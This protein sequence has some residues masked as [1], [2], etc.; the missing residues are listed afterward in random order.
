MATP[1]RRRTSSRG[2]LIFGVVAAIALL[3]FS[4]TAFYTDVLWFREI[5][6]TSVLWTTISA[7][8]VTGAVVG[9]FVGLVVYVNLVIAGR[10]AS[11]YNLFRVEDTERPDPMDRYRMLLNPYVKW[12]RLAAGIALGLLAGFGAS[13][14]WQTF[15]LYLNR[16]SFGQTDPQFG[17]DIGFYFFELPFFDLVLDWAW[18]AIVAAL[19]VSLVAHYFHGSIQPEAGLS[20][21]SS[22]VMAHVSVL[23]GLLALVKAVQY[24]LGTFELNF[25]LRGTVTGASYTDINAQLPA[26]RLLAIISIISAVLFIANIRF[27]RL[28]LPLAAVGIWV[29]TAVLA[30]AAWPA[31]VQRFSVEPQEASRER[32][33]IE[34]NIEATREGYGLDVES[35]PIA[36]TDDLDTEAIEAN[37]TL[38]S[39]VRVWDPDVLQRVYNQLQAITPFYSF[40]DV[41]IDRYEVDGEIRQ[42]LLSG[43]EL[44]VEDLTEGRSWQNE[45]LIYTHGYGVVASLANES[46]VSGQPSFLVSELPGSV[47]RDAPDFELDEPGI[48][49]GE[50]Y[51]DSEYSIVNTE[52]AE[53]DY[54]GEG[55]EATVRSNYEGEG[56]IEMGGFLRKLAFAVRERDFNMVLSD[57]IRPDS[58]IMLYKDV[59]DRVRR[60]APFLALDDDPYI[61]A[62]DGG[63]KWILDGYTTSNFYPYSQRTD[64]GEIVQSTENGSLQVEANYVRNSVKVVVDAYDGTMDFHIVD[65]DDPLMEAWRKTFPDL[66]DAEA[67]SEE[68]EEHF[69]YPED[70]LL[71]QSEL[72][73]RYHVSDTLTFYS[74]N[75]EWAIARTSS[76]SEESVTPTYLL[77]SL[78]GESGEEFVLT[79]PFTP[80]GRNNMNAILVARSDPEN[81][82]E[83]L[84][85]DF[86]SNSVVEGPAQIN[87]LINQNEEISQQITLLSDRGSNIIFGSLVNL[88]IGD[89]I[90]YVQPLFIEAASTTGVEGGG[91][92]ELQ[93]V[94]LVYGNEVVQGDSFDEALAELFD[95]D[96]PEEEE[97]PP[98]EDGEDPGAEEEPADPGAPADDL[99]GIVDEAGRVYAEAQEAL[100]DGDFE[101]YGRLIEELG[102]LLEQADALSGGGGGGAGD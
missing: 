94:I 3:L 32:P 21:I 54:Q 53:I 19:V 8:L 71:V 36:G 95:L 100:S 41:D 2:P 38:L 93:T 80:R 72:Y 1:I 28:S 77:I 9:L 78:P 98:P 91:I 4:S 17:R 52:Q 79:R 45:H 60:A 42:V 90:L 44:S 56:G 10:M 81:Y 57:D 25:S 18:F 76:T 50:N 83:L 55:E 65:D 92:P 87:N 70:L 66:F 23:L 74:G 101:T 12:L 6:I 46:T 13:S 89:S 26:L 51:E 68:L 33:F 20:G 75:D 7:Q 102:Q 88:P 5:G 62:V 48:Y 31:W 63:L 47:T 34:R 27:R 73:L 69:R 11:A 49:Y 15:T 64:L 30:G 84:T 37:E 82:G 61:T 29:L 86:P 99:Q 24:Y 59:R 22:G 40:P 43:R 14:A 96:A 97:A 58:R 85:L 35:R 39:N 16:V 67:P